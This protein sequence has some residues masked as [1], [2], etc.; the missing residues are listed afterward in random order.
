MIMQQV[1][2]EQEQE[3]VQEEAAERECLEAL[4]VC[5]GNRKIAQNHGIGNLLDVIKTGA[6]NDLTILNNY[7]LFDDL[8]DDIAPV[9]SFE[10]NGVAFEK[11]YY[12]A[13]GIYPIWSSFVKS[14]ES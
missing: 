2:S 10:C 3:Q 1:Q 4:I 11:G 12:P 5:T 14:V 9:A 7:P 13:D 6:N 8:L